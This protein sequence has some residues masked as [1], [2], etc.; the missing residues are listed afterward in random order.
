RRG[1]VSRNIQLRHT[2]RGDN[3]RYS[4]CAGPRTKNTRRTYQ[5][6]YGR[7]DM[8]ISRK[9]AALAAAASLAFTVTPSSARAEPVADFYQGKTVQLL[10]GYGVGGG[11]DTYGRL[12]ARHL[13][14]HIPGKP[15]V[16]P[17]NMPGGGSLKVA[18]Y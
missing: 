13:G 6:N 1:R 7:H 17:Q 15:Q 5:K 8:A 12:L 14:D 16:V 9:L 4:C 3:R 11:Y 2:F 18:N 10:I